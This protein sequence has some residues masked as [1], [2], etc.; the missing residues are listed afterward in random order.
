MLWSTKYYFPSNFGKL[1]CISFADAKNKEKQNVL[2]LRFNDLSLK[3]RQMDR[4]LQKSFIKLGFLEA[5]TDCL[6]KRDP[7]LDLALV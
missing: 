6:P 2:C 4:K 3:L 5:I 1:K 7:L